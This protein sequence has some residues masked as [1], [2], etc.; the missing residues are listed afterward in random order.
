MKS[1]KFAIFSI[2]FLFI[3]GNYAFASHV[4]GGNISY[5][6]TG[7]PNTYTFTLSLYRDC[8]GAAAPTQNGSAA[9]NLNFSSDC[10]GFKL[11]AAPNF[12]V[13]EI[14]AVDTSQCPGTTV[15]Q[16]G[17]IPGMQLYQYQV[18]VTLD[19]PC[20]AWT[21]S[22]T[23]NARNGSV[24]S[25][26][27]SFY[28]ETILNTSSFPTNS[29]PSLQWTANNGFDPIPYGCINSPKFYALNVVELDG[30]SL[31]FSLINP[32]SG[33]GNLI[34]FSSPAYTVGAPIPLMNLDP[35]TGLMSFTANIAGNYVVTILI[36]EFDVNGN[37]IGSMMHDF[38]FVVEICTN[39]SPVAPNSVVNYSSINTNANLDTIN[40]IISMCAGDAF[41]FDL[42]FTDPD[43]DEIQLY[44][45]VLDILPNATFTTNSTSLDTITGTVCWT[46]Q[47]GYS[48]SI[49]NI[50]ANEL[51]CIPGSATFSIELDIPPALNLSPDDSICGNQTAQILASGQGP[52]TW[53]VLSGDPMVI[54]GNFSCQNCTNPVA[55]PTITTTYLLEDASSCFLTDTVTIKVADNYGDIHADIFTPDTSICLWDCVDVDGFAEEDYTGSYTYPWSPT[56]NTFYAAGQQNAR[57][58]LFVVAQ[59]GL[60]T[61]LPGSI[62]EVCITITQGNVNDIDVYLNAP[63]GFG[64][65]PLTLSNGGTSSNYNNTCFRVGATTPISGPSGFAPFPT[66]LGGW[67]PDGGPLETALVGAPVQGF[68]SIEVDHNNATNSPGTISSWT[69]EFIEPFSFPIAASFFAWDN[70]DGMPA[71]SSIDP[72]VCPQVGGQY[73]L[74][75][76]NIDYCFTTD[77]IN[78]NLHPLPDAGNDTTVQVCLET[79]MI[80]LFDYLGGTPLNVG[81]WEDVNG[82]PVNP[83]INSNNVLD[84]LPYLYVAES[85]NG[86]LDSA[87]LTVDIIEVII[88]NTTTLDASCFTFCDGEITTISSNATHY[89]IDNGPLVTVN[90]FDSL[91]QGIYDMQ[92]YYELPDGAFCS[93]NAPGI[94]I[95]EPDKLII[96]SY[97]ATGSNGNELVVTN[98]H[99]PNA[100]YSIT[101]CKE[102]KLTSSAVGLGGNPAGIYAFNWYMDNNFAGSGTPF[103][104]QSNQDGQAYVVLND[105]ICPADT[106]FYSI[107][108]PADLVPVLKTSANGCID[109][110]VQFTDNTVQ[111]PGVNY[112]ITWEISNGHS[113]YIGQNLSGNQALNYTFYDAGIY[114]VTMILKS[115]DACVYTTQYPS[116]IEAYGPPKVAF[117]P[118]P[119]QIS[120]YEPMAN[121]VNLTSGGLDN[122]YAWK[123]GSLSSLPNGT[124]EFEPTISYPD[125]IPGKYP[126]ELTATNDKN[127]SATAYGEL[128]IINDVN[129]FAPNAFT[130]E[131][132]NYNDN[133]R[134]FISGI[135]IYDFK[136]TIYNR[137]G[138]IVWQSYDSEATWNGTY[139]NNGEYVL[140]GTYPWIVT[141]KDA[142]DDTVYEFKG[143]VNILK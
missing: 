71:T 63:G 142:I 10:G 117:T 97:I 127:C 107:L 118:S 44:S 67:L 78:I 98:P 13:E 46:Y 24:N 58:S 99:L 61:I 140:D 26:G 108:H 103:I 94:T 80:D 39:N 102:N 73:V 106:A 56:C 36:E 115:S 85:V 42:T 21:V 96:D 30:D 137:Y 112:S 90:V 72:T 79:G 29:S 89:G 35:N 128:Q 82:N 120:V 116:E 14:S 121:M 124:D 32:Q 22:Y 17:N 7:L 87:Y 8:S 81:T 130:P 31:V 11:E 6:Y 33:P 141:A 53:S 47:P 1:L 66:P 38:Q 123:F 139:G 55:T 69:I 34:P 75:A 84:S 83:L 126:I 131:G 109:L 48:G 95:G 25:N 4:S 65:F 114:D 37:L 50:T 3:G 86:C 2:L 132:N 138:E 20:D 12:L 133:W 136:L 122:S 23:L 64:Q 92:A 62:A 110:D 125:G 77:T 41:C 68:W 57:C 100:N 18:T 43:G 104:A 5:V 134:V 88:D 59:G 101:L 135:D 16:G 111:V 91:C 15:C 45:N 40:N 27:G 52:L 76:Y 60:P 143:A 19:P 93:A 9:P 54:G 129:I 28:V 49:I 113:L 105:G 119:S 74:T 70:Q 51:I